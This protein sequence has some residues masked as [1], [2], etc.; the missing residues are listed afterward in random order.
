MA[1]AQCHDEVQFSNLIVQDS[2]KLDAKYALIYVLYSKENTPLIKTAFFMN[3]FKVT[4][5]LCI[6]TVFMYNH[7][8][9]K[10]SR[11][12][13][14]LILHYTHAVKKEEGKKTGQIDDDNDMILSDTI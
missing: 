14:V 7:L 8:S 12:L 2:V 10:R 6:A 4:F 5:S 11:A 3:S 9:L 13:S 1:G